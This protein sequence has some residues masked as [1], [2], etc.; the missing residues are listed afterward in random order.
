M[1]S[2]S[3]RAL[4]PAGALLAAVAGTAALPAAA[5]P[6]V[7]PRDYGA[8][9]RF[10]SMT[11]TVRADGRAITGFDQNLEFPC[12]G[13]ATALLSTTPP[14]NI[15]ITRRGTFSA[16]IATDKGTPLVLSGRFLSLRRAT[17]HLSWR[18][19][20]HNS[21]SSCHGSATWNA[22]LRPPPP[23]RRHFVGTTSRGTR[24]S[25]FRTIERHPH[26]VNFDFGT[27]T[28]TCPD[29]S[30][31]PKRIHSVFS[32]KIVNGR[33]AGDYF[34]T[35]GEAGHVTGRFTSV[36]QATG[37]LS[38]TGRDDC[39]FSGVTWSSHRV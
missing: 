39:S 15:A 37:T 38:L 12:A 35:D 19:P 28:A 6:R 5:S 34:D 3:R 27:I 16:R 9:S 10:G 8:A 21:Y 32:F 23:P 31:E 4:A 26:A 2:I 14:R 29:G 30:T 22:T 18:G 13:G 11:F 36:T 1:P 24:A 25:F 20:A 7:H 33:F 17:G